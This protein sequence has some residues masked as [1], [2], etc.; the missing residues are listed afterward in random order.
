MENKSLSRQQIKLLFDNHFKTTKVIFGI[1]VRLSIKNEGYHHWNEIFIPKEFEDINP[2]IF[3]KERANIKN[4]NSDVKKKYYENIKLNKINDLEVNSIFIK[5]NFNDI[6]KLQLKS[7]Y[8]ESNIVLG[9]YWLFIKKNENLE[10]SLN[11][12]N[13][14]INRFILE[15]RNIE[16]NITLSGLRK[17]NYFTKIRNNR[18]LSVTELTETIREYFCSKDCIIWRIAPNKRFFKFYG[19]NIKNISIDL[20]G[21]ETQ[22]KQLIHEEIVEINKSDFKK[23]PNSN[24]IPK[25]LIKKALSFQW[26]S[27]L[28]LNLKH[29]NDIYGILLLAYSDKVNWLTSTEEKYEIARDALR[30]CLIENQSY[31]NETIEYIESIH[32]I[33]PL[34]YAG[35]M[36]ASQIHDASNY[37]GVLPL[38]LKR[39]IDKHNLDK[40]TKEK[41]KNIS[42]KIKIANNIC[43]N[44]TQLSSTNKFQ[45]RKIFL[46]HIIKNLINKF[47]PEADEASISLQLSTSKSFTYKQLKVYADS[48]ALFHALYNLLK[49]ACESLLQTEKKLKFIQIEITNDKNFVYIGI[50]DNGKGINQK[51]L[52]KIFNFLFTTKGALGTGIGLGIT[53]LIIENH[54]GKISCKSKIGRETK[55]TIMLPLA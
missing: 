30:K 43:D 15:V 1:L 10:E 2:T 55:F 37:L 24:L 46:S 42:D 51:D 50:S 25:I 44:I 22:K 40:E 53:K 48:N 35:I 7:I 3:I 26:E 39:I 29:N 33:S 52:P 21:K 4:F 20:L 31:K 41:I 27:I 5:Y 17:L 9:Y 13:I 28:I 54:H 11:I 34:I 8:D 6:Y 12:L 45:K 16:N 38:S 36:A 49:N 32:K 19:S 18:E 23:Y 47:N 14:D